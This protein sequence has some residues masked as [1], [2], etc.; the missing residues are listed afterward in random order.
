MKIID[1][2]LSKEIFFTIQNMFCSDT[3]PWYWNS[4]KS[5][6]ENYS[7]DELDNYQ[8]THKF[9]DQSLKYST[10]NIDVILQ[11]LNLFK[12]I[13]VKANLT[14]RTTQII[15]YGFHIDTDID[16]NTA[17]YYINTNNGFTEFESGEK[18]ES[19][20]NRIVIFKSNIKHT[21]TSCTNQKRRIVLNI[22]YI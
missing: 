17:I 3:F 7:C 6:Y 12:I 16:C 21:G 13:R 11:K 2:F 19:I 5:G 1:N 10:G 4:A 15:K 18:I 8:F 14:P 20:E 22:N 9:Y